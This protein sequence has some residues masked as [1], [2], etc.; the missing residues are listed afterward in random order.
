MESD[1]RDLRLAPEQAQFDVLDLPVTS[2]AW[3]S[4]TTWTRLA[5]LA[6]P[7][8][9]YASRGGR[10]TPA[11]G[12]FRCL[13]MA[14]NAE[15]TV[16]EVWGDRI[17]AQRAV[18]AMVYAIPRAEAA[19][20]GYFNV[21][22]FPAL[23]LLNL[24]DPPTLLAV[25]LDLGTIYSTDIRVIRQWAEVIACHPVG[26][27]GIIYRSRHTTDL[28]VVLWSDRPKLQLQ[29]KPAGMFAESDA[30]YALAGMLGVKLSFAH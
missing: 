5:Q 13:Y 20:W 2:E 18:G 14:E 28:C 23:K 7:D 26:F 15:T 30:A 25:G 12:D 10:F 27:S 8:H 6:H 1:K 9:F 29:I 24:T 22:N 17:Y 16:A 19:E 4:A 21:D 3:L 11:S